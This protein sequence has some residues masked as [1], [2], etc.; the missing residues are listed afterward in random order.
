M[1]TDHAVA[2]AQHNKALTRASQVLMGIVTGIVADGHLHD[3][4]VQMLSTWLTDNQDVASVW[5]GT[6]IAQMLRTAL[7]DGIITPNERAHLLQ[8]LQALIGSD[9]SDTGATAPSVAGLP[10]D[11]DSTVTLQGVNVCHTGEFMYGTRAHC[12]KL[13]ER[14]GG[15]PAQ[16]VNR[17]TAYLVVGTH[18]SPA[19]V[20]TS[21]GR[22][23]EQAM[24]IR[25]AGH[26]ILIIAEQRWL[27]ACR[28]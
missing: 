24:Q 2:K 3:M 8:E 13:T 16:A 9:F 18:V 20:N 11:T 7:A 26:P 12:E 1:S 17:K 10:Y 23:I 22:K 27:E 5:P 28:S 14:M 15:T 21:Y 19:W 25:E 4:E 6:A